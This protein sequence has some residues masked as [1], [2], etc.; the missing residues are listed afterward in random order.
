MITLE[1]LQKI[2]HDDAVHSEG[3]VL[4]KQTM[5]LASSSAELLDD[6]RS[7]FC[8]YISHG[9]KA[10]KP[11]RICDITHVE[12]QTI[13]DLIKSNLPASPDR[14][15]PTSLNHDVDYNLRF[16]RSE[17]GDAS[18]IE[19]ALL[20]LLYVTLNHGQ[21]IMIVSAAGSRTRTGVLRLIRSLWVLGHSAPILHGCVVAKQGRGIAIAGNKYA[22]KTTSLLNLC[23]TRGYNI[24]ANDRAMLVAD[25]PGKRLKA[26]GVPTVVNIR[27]NTVKPFPNF[28]HL[29]DASLYSVG[30][31]AKALNVPITRDVE[32]GAVV[33]LSYLSTCDAPQTRRLSPDEAHQIL[34]THLLSTKE[35]EWANEVSSNRT[36]TK[37]PATANPPVLDAVPCFELKSNETQLEAVASILDTWCQSGLS[38]V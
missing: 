4:D 2:G 36:L 9:D 5:R 18:V 20:G 22:G 8:P 27:R 24:V 35:Y 33:F 10:A 29:F 28:H 25:T 23:T 19:D 31:L 7:F 30:D 38:D 15:I 26:V 12:N 6:L 32:I 11:A 14:L 21:D 17:L 1:A 16:F 37:R 3:F 13:F 34:A